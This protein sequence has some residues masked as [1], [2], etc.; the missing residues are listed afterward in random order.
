MRLNINDR[1]VWF[2]VFGLTIKGIVTKT[3]K[4]NLVISWESG[5]TIQYTPDMLDGNDVVI[6]L[7]FEYYRNLKL[8]ALKI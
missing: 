5:R 2:D 4:D 1:V 7:D 3:I 8:E 6:K